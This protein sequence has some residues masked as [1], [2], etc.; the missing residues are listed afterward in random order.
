M[1]ANNAIDSEIETSFPYDLSDFKQCSHA[2][3]DFII[4]DL[5]IGIYQDV[6]NQMIAITMTGPVDQWFG[7]GFGN[8]NMNRMYLI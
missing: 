5:E 3:I 1:A 2:P 4:A 7:V 8:N 6:T